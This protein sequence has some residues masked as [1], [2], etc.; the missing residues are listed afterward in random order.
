MDKTKIAIR[1]RALLEKTVANGCT[2]SEATMAAE[3]ANQMLQEH[4]LSLTEL[5]VQS[6]KI[7]KRTQKAGNKNIDTL[8]YSTASRIAELCNCKV[9]RSGAELIWFGTQ[10]DTEIAKHMSDMFMAIHDIEKRRWKEKNVVGGKSGGHSFTVGMASRLNE[11]L[12]MMI[13]ANQYENQH[14]AKAKGT[15]LVVVKN[16]LVESAY[17]TLGMK[18]KRGT[19][20]TGAKSHN[21]YSAGRAAGDRVNITRGVG[22]GERRMIA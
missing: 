12:A 3:K 9:W 2:E 21:G 22:G 15:D 5:E 14:V 11:R 17:A 16:Q 7:G 6:E 8:A 19:S 1:I 20:R 18:M 13:V 10:T 4:N